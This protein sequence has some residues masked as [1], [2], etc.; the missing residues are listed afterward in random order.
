MTT[1][2]IEPLAHGWDLPALWLFSVIVTELE[3]QNL[4][5]N[6]SMHLI[7]WGKEVVSMY[8]GHKSLWDVYCMQ[9]N[10]GKANRTSDKIIQFGTINRYEYEAVMTQHL[11]TNPVISFV[12]II[13]FRKCYNRELEC[14]LI[15]FISNITHKELIIKIKINL[16]SADLL[17]LL[18]LRGSIC[19][20][21]VC[22]SDH[23]HPK[24]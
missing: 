16:W 13:Y 5:A 20:V 22:L 1:E 24:K 11:T 14:K 6:K 2:V 21:A 19:L 12:E 15:M 17:F 7:L 23:T 9:Q 18:L 4:G 10:H 3:L 8:P